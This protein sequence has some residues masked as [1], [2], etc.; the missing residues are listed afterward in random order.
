MKI[1]TW[2]IAQAQLIPDDSVPSVGSVGFQS[3]TKYPGKLRWHCILSPNNGA[4]G[5]PDYAVILTAL[6]E[7]L[8]A[9]QARILFN[10]LPTGPVTEFDVGIVGADGVTVLAAPILGSVQIR[11]DRKGPTQ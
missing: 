1:N 4:L 9:G 6:T 5:S 8:Q 11:I 7:E 10:A 2:T 3:I